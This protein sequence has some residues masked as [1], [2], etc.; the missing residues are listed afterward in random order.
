MWL[1]DK[2]Q[3]FE[4]LDCSKGEK[5]ERWGR[6]Y[7]VRPDPQ[8]IWDTPRR[9]R[10]WNDRDA[11]YRRSETGGGSWEFFK[12]LTEW[13]VGWRN[14]RFCV[15][16]MGFKHTGLFPEQA[17]NWALMTELIKKAN[18]PVRVLNLFA[19]T[20]GATVACAAAGAEVCHVDAAKNMVERAKQN[21]ALSGL[22]DCPV[23]YIVDDCAKFVTREIKRGKFYDAIIM[24]PPS[25]GRG[26][27][28][29]VWKLEDNICDF[30][31]LC[32]GVLSD[33]PLFVLLNSYT[34]GLQPTVLKNLLATTFADVNGKV[35][36]YEVCLPTSEGIMLPCGASGLFLGE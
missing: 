9:N 30:L 35:E 23:R 26:S 21:M 4:L 22:S 8:A 1:S 11:R 29:E 31:K 3:D 6:Y 5:L 15:K 27:N 10:H 19:Y 13:T 33:K 36:A 14:L 7:L 18:R 17:A 20:G 2:W 12:P 34:T 16:P 28:G 24:D 32:K 25:Y